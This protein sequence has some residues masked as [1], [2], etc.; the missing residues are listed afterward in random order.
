MSLQ[1]ESFFHHNPLS[2]NNI[3]SIDKKDFTNKK[4]KDVV[5]EQKISDTTKNTT[6][7]FQRL[8]TIIQASLESKTPFKSL[9]VYRELYQLCVDSQLNKIE[10]KYFYNK[11][12][13]IFRK[14]ENEKT[15]SSWT[16]K[17]DLLDAI[18]FLVKENKD[19]KPLEMRQAPQVNPWKEGTV[20]LVEYTSMNKAINKLNRV[21]QSINNA[22]DLKAHLEE[23]VIG[24]HTETAK[25]IHNLTRRESWYGSFLGVIYRLITKGAGLLY[26]KNSPEKKILE[27]MSQF[28]LKMDIQSIE[29]LSQKVKKEN[30]TKSSYQFY[31][32]G[33]RHLFG[34]SIHDYKSIN[35]WFKRDLTTGARQEYLQNTIEK[36]EKIASNFGVNDNGVSQIVI[37]NSDARLRFHNIEPGQFGKSQELTGKVLNQDAE[38]VAK[39]K[40]DNPSYYK[41]K[42]KFSTK[43]LLGRE[44]NDPIQPRQMNPKTKEIFE[45]RMVEISKIEARIISL[46]NRYTISP[47]EIKELKNLEKKLS[48]LQRKMLKNGNTKNVINFSQHELLGG[49]YRFFDREG[50]VQ[51]IQRLAPAD[52]HNYVAPLNGTPLSHK[53]AIMAIK[54]KSTELKKYLEGQNIQDVEELTKINN[55]I[56]HYEKLEEVFKNQEL[57]LGRPSQA[58]IDIFGTNASVSTTGIRNQSRILAQNDRKVMLFKHEDDSLSLHVFIGATGVNRV[59]VDPLTSSKKQGD[60]QG[61]MQFG[62]D[63]YQRQSQAAKANDKTTKDHTRK[64]KIGQHKGGFPINGSTVISYY[65][66]TDFTTLKKIKEFSSVGSYGEGIDRANIEIRAKMGNPILIKTEITLVKALKTLFSDEVDFKK[67]PTIENE[68]NKINDET[69][70]LLK[71]LWGG[72][73]LT[74]SESALKAKVEALI[75]KK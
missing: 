55:E 73:T 27:K 17:A 58:T 15:P 46:K 35:E 44:T 48:H 68:E 40:K 39:S 42:Y 4:I 33:P 54:E 25:T 38:Q 72:K 57:L 67:I 29:V 52:I 34:N 43:N 61:D 3:S 50:A 62:A 32:R 59:D 70:K 71:K 13:E 60:R 69:F 9:S 22:N 51:V 11:I 1:V 53:E 37:S 49:I 47:Q 66:P 2:N 8:N 18:D 14:I 28:S 36:E 19:L 74:P 20:P 26:K 65:L 12:E 24:E 45:K 63:K 75:N 30:D 56:A 31:Y 6:Q 16:Q 5:A 41:E 7:S 23:D 64:L 21:S 10:Q